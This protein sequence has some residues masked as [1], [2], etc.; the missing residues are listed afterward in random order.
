MRKLLLE[1]VKL[2]AKINKN[3]KAYYKAD[4]MSALYANSLLKSVIH[5]G[6]KHNREAYEKIGIIITGE[7][8]YIKDQITSAL[9]I[10]I[11]SLYTEALEFL[12]EE[13]AFDTLKFLLKQECYIDIE[14]LKLER[15][16]HNDKI[17]KVELELL[18]YEP[19][20]LV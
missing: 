1:L 5:I 7:R 20:E 18:I 6:S 13:K 15:M 12:I 9:L 4:I 8:S 14:I 16:L 17:L 19:D 10:K 3:K 2:I 11:L